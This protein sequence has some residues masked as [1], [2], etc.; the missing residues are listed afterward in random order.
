MSARNP[1]IPIF[2]DA[3][4]REAAKKVLMASAG[5]VV[6]IRPETRSDRQNRLFHA[7]VGELSENVKHNGAFWSPEKWKEALIV[8]LWGFDMMPALDGDGGVLPIR[9]SSATLSVHDMNELI[10]FTYMVGARKGYVFTEPRPGDERNA[11]APKSRKPKKDA[12]HGEEEIAD[13]R[14]PRARQA[15]RSV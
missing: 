3:S 13:A 5:S 4:R 1:T 14:D 9:R 10:E 15:D 2:D 6:V 12:S 8:S 7:L 11:P